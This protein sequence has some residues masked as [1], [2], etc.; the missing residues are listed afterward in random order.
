L[1]PLALLLPLPLLVALAAFGSARVADSL[2]TRVGGA[3]SAIADLL[4]VE[5]PLEVAE[6][7]ELRA[8]MTE[9]VT[10]V[11]ESPAKKPKPKLGKRPPGS[12]GK[13]IFVSAAT[14][15]KLA[16]RGGRPRGTP[17]KAHGA[18]PAGLRLTG[19]SALGIGL[20]DGDVLTRALGRPAL[21]AGS[22][23]ESVIVA[24]SK[25]AKVLDGEF[26]RGNDRYVI[27]VEQPYLEA[28]STVDSASALAPTVTVKQRSGG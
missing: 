17:V 1:R 10:G 22:V 13:G 5:K 18:R 2:G 26:Y 12:P 23:V 7:F 25:R 21:S 15:L 4:S 20:E 27:Q 16:S 6:P 19:V 28:M 11:A 3:L 8:S 14:V 9:E 24:R